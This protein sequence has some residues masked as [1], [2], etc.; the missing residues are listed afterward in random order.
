MV[1]IVDLRDFLGLDSDGL[2]LPHM[3]DSHPLDI[4]A[5]TRSPLSSHVEELYGKGDRAL[6]QVAQRGSGVSFYGD[7]QDPSGCL[8]VQPIVGY[9]L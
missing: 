2:V 5:S 3:L 4:Y 1:G 6:E 8:P 9:L 7:L